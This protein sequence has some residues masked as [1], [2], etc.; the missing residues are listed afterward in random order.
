MALGAG[1]FRGD[2]RGMVMWQGMRL[3]LLG[4]VAGIPA[5]LALTRVMVSMVV[6]IPTWDPVVFA[7]VALLLGAVGLFAA[8]APSI[9]ATRVDPV[10]ALRA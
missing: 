9:R 10:D 6:G 8:Y 2:V 5:A 7:A 4:I 3:A 1:I